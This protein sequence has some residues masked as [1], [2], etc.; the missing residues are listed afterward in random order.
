MQIDAIIILTENIYK[1]SLK[2]ACLSTIWI[3]IRPTKILDH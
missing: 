1:S 3:Q 2:Y